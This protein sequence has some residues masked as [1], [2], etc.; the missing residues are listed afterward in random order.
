[1]MKHDYFIFASGRLKRKDNTVFLEYGN[2]ERKYLPVENIDT[3]HV[4]GEV[5][6][7]NKLLDYMSEYGIV[8]NFYNYYGYYSGSYC[9]RKRNVSGYS[10]VNQV[11]HYIDP[12]KRLFLAEQFIISAIFH[13]M[14]NLRHYNGMQGYIDEINNERRNIDEVS[15]IT[16]LM[17][18]EGTARNIYYSAFNEILKYGF[19][20]EKRER[21][22][23]NDPVNVL[24]SFG[25]SLMY[26]TVLAEIYKTQLDP[27]ISY[28]HE[29]STR[30]FSL[31]LD[32]AEIFKPLIVDP[33]IFYVVNN[34]IISLDNFESYEGICILNED[35]KKKFIREYENKL[36]T[37]VKHR[38]LNRN[39]S[40]KGFIRLECYKIIKHLLDD[41]V[42]KPLKA[43]W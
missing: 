22:P 6:M 31:S 35:G 18:I 38:K 43:W 29:P 16:S 25:N 36:T 34:K 19:K 42:Y 30:R 37:T 33:L 10:L 20:M 1:M 41:E 14:R 39:V 32:I 11:Q 12:E 21:R 7:N 23:P 4:F 17:G 15:D 2:D 24:I 13:M 5:D 3:I 27:T 28:L 26:T 8:I 40:Y 9:P